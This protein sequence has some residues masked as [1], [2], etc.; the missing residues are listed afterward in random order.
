M[1]SSSR[2][3]ALVALALTVVSAARPGPGQAQPTPAPSPEQQESERLFLEGRALL[4]AGDA[5]GACAKFED[6]RRKNPRAVGTLLNLGL[7]NERAGKV[8]TALVMY[9]QAFDHASAAGLPGQTQAARDKIAEL[10]PLV[11][12]LTFTWQG[13]P[14]PGTR[15]LVDDTVVEVGRTAPYLV[16]PGKHAI[17]VTAPGRLPFEREVDAG[18]GQA[19]AIEIPQL[20]EPKTRT[21]VQ[22]ERVSQTRSTVGKILTGS[23]AALL[24]GSGVLAYTAKSLYDQQF[25]G[26]TP[27]CV[28]RDGAA[29]LCTPDGKSAIDRSRTRANIAT[30]TGAVGLAAVATGVVLWWTAPKERSNRT[31]LAAWVGSDGAGVTLSG[32]F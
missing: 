3:V 12:S 16:D 13:T 19:S 25:E 1:R 7:C 10:T 32:G 22:V 23:G 11:P 15:L 18:A 17:V 4:E 9:Q 8:A 6:S 27:A 26:A 24:V 5:A 14:L 21:V 28:A 2:C 29:N 31:A 20:E 30:I